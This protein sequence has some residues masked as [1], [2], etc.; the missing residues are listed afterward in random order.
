MHNNGTVIKKDALIKGK[1]K[2]KKRWELEI[3]FK[4]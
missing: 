4:T 3:R 1:M 2:R